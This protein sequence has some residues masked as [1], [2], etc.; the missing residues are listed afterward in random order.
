MPSEVSS[1]IGELKRRRVF[2][3]LVG[4][5]IAAFAILQVIEPVMHGLQ[6]P[7][8]VLSAVVIAL[9][10]GFPIT[11]VLAWVFDLKMTG[12]E[13]TAPSPALAARGWPRCSSGWA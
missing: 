10:V 7:E 6:L 1:W 5:G 12:V 4:Y 11:V 9:G 3:A 13:R 2:R 8:W